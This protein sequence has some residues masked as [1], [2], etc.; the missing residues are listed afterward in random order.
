MAVADPLSPPS[1]PPLDSG[2]GRVPVAVGAAM[3]AVFSAAF[4]ARSAFT[5]HG[6]T[7]FSLFD[8]AMIS[9]S[10]GRNLAEGHGLVWNAGGDPVEGFTNLLWTL[11]MAAVHLAGVSAARSSLA[12]MISGVALLVA[13]VAV[14]GAIAR[15]IAPEAPRVAMLAIVSTALLYPLLFWTLRGMEVGLLTLLVSLAVLLALRIAE[16]PAGRDVA[17]LALVLVAGYLTRDDSLT[18]IAVIGVFVAMY[19]RRA[20]LWLGV[21]VVGAVAVKTGLRLVYYG[22][23]LPNTYHLK[24]DGEPLTAR[25]RRGLIAVANIGLVELFAPLALAIVA[26]KE[27]GSVALRLLGALVVVQC[28]Y[29]VYVGGDVWEFLEIT[30]RYITPVVPCLLVLAS[31]GL[32]RLLAGTT[33]SSR[34]AWLL[35]AG[36]VAVAVVNLV[37]AESQRA[38]AELFRIGPAA[39]R[40]AEIVVALVLAVAAG[41]VAMRRPRSGTAFAVGAVLLVVAVS[42]QQFVHWTQDGAAYAAADDDMAR[43]GL[44]LGDVTPPRTTV[45]V[46]WAGAIP[47]FSRRP[48]VDLL[49]KSDPVIARE[50]PRD[51]P[52]TPGH[53]KFDYEYSLGRLRPQVVAQLWFVGPEPW[54]PM[55]RW[56][57]TQIARQ[58]LPLSQWAQLYVTRD[59]PAAVQRELK[60]RLPEIVRDS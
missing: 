22:E 12:I 53:D 25:V 48:S 58:P 15:R 57:Y 24:L 36:F 16:R 56:G 44:M 54:R 13:N 29:S 51:V 41:V 43:Y 1:A 31:V 14:V 11:W 30:N 4:I 10:Y 9:M 33:G 35:A 5:Y 28:V 49:G 27:R 45:A 46:A 7:Y 60:R 55:R 26:L 8:D 21:A 23:A 47:Y 18:W 40:H 6:K 38:I 37:L 3:I 19:A 20:A 2:A 32:D 50:P 52:F 39:D 17:A 59:V 34:T 42:G